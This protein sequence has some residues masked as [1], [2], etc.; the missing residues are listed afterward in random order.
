MEPGARAERAKG[1]AQERF[2][3]EQSSTPSTSSR[4]SRSVTPAV[5]PV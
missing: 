4:D 3:R 5:L 2:I 1:G